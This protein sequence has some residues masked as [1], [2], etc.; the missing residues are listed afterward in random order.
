M[1]L[2]FEWHFGEPDVKEFFKAKQE[3]GL[4]T[5]LDEIPELDR[6]QTELWNAFMRLSKTGNISLREIESYINIF[7]IEDKELFVDAILEMA[8]KNLELRRNGN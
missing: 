6:F 5:P 7:E 3:I 2:E 8:S 1:N 4:P